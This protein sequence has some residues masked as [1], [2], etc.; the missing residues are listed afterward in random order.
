V[1]RSIRGTVGQCGRHGCETERSPG[2]T[3]H[4]KSKCGK[5]ALRQEFS[6]AQRKLVKSWSIDANDRLVL[7][8]RVESATLISESKAVFDRQ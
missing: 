7:V 3:I 4:S 2:G 8:E 6:S 5:G 1:A